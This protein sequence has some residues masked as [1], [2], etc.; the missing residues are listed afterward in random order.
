MIKRKYKLETIKKDGK[1]FDNLCVV[2]PDA[3]SMP[4]RFYATTVYYPETE[5]DTQTYYTQI[6]AD[7]FCGSERVGTIKKSDEFDTPKD[8]KK[9][10]EEIFEEFL[11]L[12]T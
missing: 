1:A 8:A 10:I 2:K 4:S 3:Y 5:Q 11:A 6:Q 9:W 12:A 7:V